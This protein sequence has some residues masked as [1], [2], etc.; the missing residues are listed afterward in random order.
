MIKNYFKIAWR[1][2]LKRKGVFLINILGLAIRITCCVLICAYIYNQLTYDTYAKETKNIY[3]IEHYSTDGN[4]VNVYPSVDVAVGSGLKEA[5]PEISAY[6][7]MVPFPGHFMSYR[8]NQYKENSIAFVDSNFF[9]IFTIPF[10]SGNE[11]TALAAPNNIV[12]TKEFSKKYFGSNDPIGKQ[13]NYS[14]FQN[15]LKVTG[16]I[17]SVPNNSHFHFDA[18]ISRTTIPNVKDSGWINLGTFT[19]LKLNKNV[20]ANKLQSKFPQIVAEHAVSEIQ[21]NRGVTL[22]KAQQSVNTLVL[23]LRPVTDI[24]LYSKTK[25]EIEPPG[26][27]QYVYIFG[28]L[29]VFILL[30]A[31]SNFVNLATASAA[32][33]SREIGIRK[34]MGSSKN[35]LVFQFLVVIFLPNSFSNSSIPFGVFVVERSKT[36]KIVLSLMLIIL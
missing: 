6:T 3:R 2:L 7:R 8:E 30:L 21:R 19:Y 27:I 18:F 26:D 10:I 1:N 12:I 33:R 14:V 29:A 24:H 11:K 17:E 4:A 15:D 36:L 23:K 9:E 28:A 16:V 32:A 5:F 31:C 25:Y 13:L 34:V 20:D 35:Q 22:D